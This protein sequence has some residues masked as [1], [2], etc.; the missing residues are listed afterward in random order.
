MTLIKKYIPLAAFVAITLFSI[1]MYKI[2]WGKPLNINHYFERV[3]IEL[4]LKN[5]EILSSL[6]IIDN[7]ILDFHS[8]DLSDASP[9]FEK[10]MAQA[11]RGQVELLKSYN[12]ADMNDSQLLSTDILLWFLEDA[13]AG[14]EFLYYDYPVNQMFGV[15]NWF[16]S[17][18]EGMHAVVSEK[19]ARRYI[20]R[21][22]KLGH[23]FNQ[24]LEGLGL[25]ESM[26]ITPPQ[27]VIDRVLNEMQGFVDTVPKENIL[28]TS[29]LVKI[30]AL[31]DISPA[32][33]EEL[34]KDVEDE[35]TRS[36]YP[37]YQSLIAY[38]TDLRSRATTEDGVWKFPNGENYYA[39]M[40]RRMTTTNY[41]PA[42]I[43][44]IGL[45]EV[46]RIL[47]EMEIILTDLG[48]KS[49]S[50]A[51]RMSSLA[52]E[53]RFLYE[54]SDEGREA[55]LKQY[56]AIIDSISANLDHVFNVRPK[57]PL[58]IKRVPKFKETTSA[59]AYY[60]IPAMDGTRPG[61]FF[62]NLRDVKEI[63]TFGMRTLAYH[64]GVPGHHF[65]LATAMEMTGVP[66]FRKILPFVAY[67]EGWALYAERVAWEYGFIPDQYSN[68]GRLQA[69]L[70]RAVRLVV[71]TGIH[72]KRWARKEA[73]EY[74]L[75]TTGM[76]QKEVT[77][78]VERYIVMPGQA[79]AYK[80]GMMKIMEL[81]ER[82]QSALGEKFDIRDFHDVVIQNGAM[83]LSILEQLVDRYIKQRQPTS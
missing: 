7:T 72:Y 23:K 77:A 22:T 38:F 11:I 5:P 68:L 59:I 37:A 45:D 10:E 49:G 17:F 9:A 67:V 43:H 62:T 82:A 36:V 50:V 19:S 32:L 58:Q 52:K 44:Q 26:G 70:F 56:T 41:T 30:D 48:Y 74:M 6:A 47:G 60:Q 21:L 39:Y 53:A 79:C 34:L 35:I 20:I 83:P 76:G 16:P 3:F 81:R 12:R 8:D 66:M 25:R 24:V 27:F 57:A 28:Y 46:D 42:E 51:D 15:Q 14:E 69:E 31:T 73:I 78:E 80:V 54:D 33:K 18:M 55:I 64:E 75:T 29:F 13:V 61:S 1:W 4:L 65:Q 40:L 71:D 63:P 2:V